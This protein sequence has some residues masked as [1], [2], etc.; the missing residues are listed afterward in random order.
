M[1]AALLFSRKDNICSNS[2]HNRCSPTIQ[3]NI[4]IPCTNNFLIILDILSNHHYTRAKEVIEIWLILFLHLFSSLQPYQVTKFHGLPAQ[5]GK[6]DCGPAAAATVLFLSGKNIQ[7]WPQELNN[8]RATLVELTHYLQ[9]HG[10]DV[11]AY[12][13]GWDDLKYFLENSPGRPLI[14]HSKRE[15]GHYLVLLGLIDGWLAV[16]DPG[17]GVQTVDPRQFQQ[18]FSGYVLHFPTLPALPAVDRL[19]H[20]TKERLALLQHS[21]Y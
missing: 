6:W 12:L 10:L 1:R 2:N 11:E 18:Q 9:S 3:G 20:R 17:R 19:I 4:T 16:A 14:T 5:Q 21:I 8:R 7:P 15:Q 13:L